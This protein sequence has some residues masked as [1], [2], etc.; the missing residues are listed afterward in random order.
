MKKIFIRLAIILGSIFLIISLI[1]FGGYLYTTAW[2]ATN[3]PP[4]H[5]SWNEQQ[6]ADLLAIDN[7][8][9]HNKMIAGLTFFNEGSLSPTTQWLKESKWGML[10]ALFLGWRELAM[11]AREALHET[12]RTGRGDVLLA[13]GIPVADIALKCHKIEL[14]KELIRRGANP[15]H[16]YIAWDAPVA[17]TNGGQT[18]LVWEAFNGLN[19]NFETYLEPEVRIE[20]LEFMLAHG[21]NVT[22]APNQQLAELYAIFPLVREEGNDKG[23]SIA[24]ALRQGMTLND[25]HK[26]FCVKHMQKC[27]PALLKELQQEGLLPATSETPEPPSPAE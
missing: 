1:G 7:E 8:L 24:W 11:P 19:L 4:F 9:R 5:E 6:R 16:A 18:N 26:D 17:A 13:S 14:F 3:P 27:N 22:S 12:M 23:L 10:P 15:N 25:E 20:L 21:G 2:R